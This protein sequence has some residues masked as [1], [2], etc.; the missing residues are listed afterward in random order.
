M[1]R[2]KHS[3]LLFAAATLLATACASRQ[4]AVY[5]R[6][7]PLESGLHINALNDC[8]VATNFSVQD[9]N[10]QKRTLTFSVYSEDLYDAVA[11][12]QMALG[13]TLVYEGKPM[14]VKKIQKDKNGVSI[15]GEI[16]EGGAWLTP[17]GGG[18]YRATI[19]DDHSIYTLIGK[20]T[21]PL[22]DDF[23]LI[24]CGDEPTD[25]SDTIRTGQQEYIDQVAKQGR[26]NF[27]AINT[28][29]TIVQGK[30]KEIRRHWIP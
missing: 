25:P 13:D 6:I 19:W 14:T 18:T 12:S 27:D 23:I 4:V 21:L 1:N 29:V 30:V 16:E 3:F 17:N 22:A 7:A 8:T 10:W 11:V 24:D 26:D 15:N 2:F 5:H 28:R 20:A 9:F